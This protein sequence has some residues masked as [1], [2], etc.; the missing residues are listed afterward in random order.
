MKDLST[1]EVKDLTGVSL[2]DLKDG[3]LRGHPSVDLNK[4]L[5][6]DPLRMMRLIRF[7]AKY[8]WKVPLAVLKI[9]KANAKRI[10]IV[11]GERIR[12]ELEKVMKLGKLK[13][14]I[15]LMKVVGL[16]EHVFPEIQEMVGVKH[17]TSRGVHQEGDVFK[18]TMLVLQN[19]KPG[20]LNQLAA[21]LHDVGKPGTREEIGDKIKFLGHETVGAEMAEAIMRRLKFDRQTITT[22]KRMVEGHMRPHRLN[23]KEGFSQKAIRK[24][25]RK[26]GEEVVDSILDLA[27]ADALGNL[28]PDN[29]IPDLRKEIE[30]IQST[31]PVSPKTVLDGGEVMTLLG[32]T[33]GP[34]VGKALLMVQEWEDDVASKGGIPTKEDAK[35]YLKENF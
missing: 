11:S 34:D 25:I 29:Y 19:A 15:K 6:D 21:L 20:V 14:A 33:P 4:I 26:V 32:L 2:S 18:H 1:G 17:D 5:T 35:D 7:Q 9:V 23:R 13:T 12:D 31:S 27:E 3:L 22:V 10:G 24:F 30:K 28:P 16:L 8:G